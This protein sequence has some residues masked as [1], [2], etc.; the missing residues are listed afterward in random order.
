MTH[1][2]VGRTEEAVKRKCWYGAE[3]S[4]V[5]RQFE[6]DIERLGRVGERAEGDQ[7]DPGLGD[8]AQVGERDAARCLGQRAAA[9]LRY[10][11]AHLFERHVVEQDDVGAAD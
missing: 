3:G 1:S 10:R 5:R 7:V 6:A 9:A 11:L 8:G 4:T 2:C